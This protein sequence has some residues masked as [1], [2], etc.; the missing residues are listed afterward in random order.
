M[1]RIKELFGRVR[2]KRPLLDH[3]VRMYQR[4]QADGGD[5][6]ASSV[7][8][9][10]FLSLFPILLIAVYVTRQ[11][12]GDDAGTQIT[13]NLG[14]YLGKAAAASIATVVQNSAGKAG[15]IGLVGT[16]LS[17]LG[18][19]EALR[20]AIRTMWHQNIKAGNIVTRKIADVIALVGLFAVIAA[21]VVVS[22]AATA[23]TESVVGFLGL[24][25]NLG[26]KA[27]TIGL[28]YL[29]GALVD[30]AIFL[31]LFLRLAKVPT[32]IRQVLKGAVFGAVGFEVLKFFGA[33][34]IGRTTSK[35][36]A[37][38]GTFAT[39]VGLLLFLNLVS[40]LVLYTAA[41]TVTAPYDDDVAPSGTADPKQA[42]KAGIPEEYA[43]QDL[44]VTEDGAP[45][46]LAPALRDD[47]D[48]ERSWS[49]KAKPQ[50]PEQAS[51]APAAVV[52]AGASTAGEKQV[53]LAARAVSA[54]S[55]AVVGAVGLYGA[56]TLARMVRR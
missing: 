47:P 8:F 27:L 49:S 24:S 5:R 15:L 40:R 46:P 36:E 53:V 4:Y 23:A 54:A 2:R 21:S 20:E 12:L 1:N 7:T 13:S 29:L 48:V 3:L 43:G 45:T 37:T 52:P 56:R 14:P 42:R 32:P 25:Q 51:E 10:W 35:G 50:E 11:V 22:G 17:G 55:F 19:I 41:F 9:Y 39:V 16:L 38:Y 30:V 26:A 6:L 28:S 33:F 31:W 44:N 34:Y 18:W